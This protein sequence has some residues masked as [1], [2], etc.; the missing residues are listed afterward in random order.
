MAGFSLAQR[1][2]TMRSA[3]GFTLIELLIVVAIIGILAAIAVPNLMAARM[4]G[5]EASAIGS[6]R[7]IISAQ[8]DYDSMNRGYATDLATLAAGCPGSTIPFITPDLGNNGAFKSG[9]TFVLAAGML[10]VAGPN[11][12][13]GTATQTDFYATATPLSFGST[14]K[15]GFASNGS[16]AIWQDTGG[17]PPVEPFTVG[18]TI[19][20][21]AQ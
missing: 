15:R 16:A 3:R 12:C 21:L 8:M 20:P 13:N 6:M 17:A 7:A 10:A 19:S 9:Y 18:G 11:D 1:R 2:F 5:N 14:G 4:S